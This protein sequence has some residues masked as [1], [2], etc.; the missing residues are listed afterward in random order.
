MPESASTVC[1]ESDLG[2]TGIDAPLILIESPSDLLSEQPTDK[3]VLKDPAHDTVK[4]R[5]MIFYATTI[6]QFATHILLRKLF[7]SGQRSDSDS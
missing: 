3:M 5:I 1:F 4:L 2:F 7:C 6:S